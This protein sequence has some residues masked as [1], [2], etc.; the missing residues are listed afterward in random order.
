MPGI[1]EVARLAGVSTATV[2][3]AL[4]GNGHVSSGKCRTSCRYTTMNGSTSP[5]PS[6]EKTTVE[7]RNRPSRGSSRQKSCSVR[8][9]LVWPALLTLVYLWWQVRDSNPRS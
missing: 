2:S 1:I 8:T 7:M 3:R 6:D 4:S 5:V 9:D